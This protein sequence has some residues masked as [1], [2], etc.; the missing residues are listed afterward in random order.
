MIRQVNSA[1]DLGKVGK[2]N[3]PELLSV[4]AKFDEIFDVIADHD[5]KK[6][7]LAVESMRSAGQLHDAMQV[8]TNRPSDEEIES[9]VNE[10]NKAKQARDFARADS[11][12]KQLA[13][14]GVT[15]E[16]TKDGVRWKRK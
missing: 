16:D 14:A 15:L 2:E 9:L 12:R 3:V 8:K 5:A 10:R 11:I 1:A 7:R 4:L 13:D 6:L